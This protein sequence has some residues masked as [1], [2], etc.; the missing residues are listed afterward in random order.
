MMEAENIQELE[1]PFWQKKDL[2]ELNTEKRSKNC[3]W[4]QESRLT[5]MKNEDDA[6]GKKGY[7]YFYTS[8]SRNINKL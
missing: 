7:Y 6:A 2:P 8:K 4:S 1:S 5:Y 3:L